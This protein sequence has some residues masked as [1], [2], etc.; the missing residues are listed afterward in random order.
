MPH[1]EFNLEEVADYLH[2]APQDV[3]RLMRETDVP[4]HDRGGRTIFYRAEI[5]AWASRRIIGLPTKRLDA[6]H[7]KT[8]RGLRPELTQDALIGELLSEQY[9]DLEL[10][11]KTR[12]SVI[13]DMVAL[14]AKTDRVFDPRELLES[15]EAREALCPTAVEGGL[16]LLHARHHQEYRFEGSFLVL[17]RTI[18]PVPFGAPDGRPT[19]LFLLLCCQD[20]R[21]HLHTL[22][23]LALMAAKTNVLTALRTAATREEAFAALIAA[24]TEVLPETPEE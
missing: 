21:I 3:E 14:A 4:H 20:E 24:E 5:E 12:P 1:R 8:L 13:R 16:A 11:S 19:V 7:E 23:R 22:A 17:G 15:V 6:Y 9:I 18:Q 10:P 2:V